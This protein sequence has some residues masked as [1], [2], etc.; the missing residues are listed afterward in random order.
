MSSLDDLILHP[1]TLQLAQKIAHHLP[2][3]LIIDGPAGSGTLTLAAALAGEVNSP[4][5]VLQPK[6]K[7][8]GEFVVDLSE[9]SII[10]DDIRRLY[11][12]TRTKQPGEQVYI[13]DTG[14]KSMTLGA[15]N[16]F[17]KLL[18]EPR[19]GLHFIIATHQ[20]AQLLPTITSRSQRLSLLPVTDA[21][22][23][24]LIKDLNIEDETKRTRL[25]FVGRGLPALIKRLV[26]DEMLYETR[27]AIMRDAK[28]MISGNT[29]DK[30]TIAHHYR[31]NR[32]GA[33]TL[34]DDMNHQLRTVVRSQPDQKLVSD[35]DK[36]LST[37]G[38]I[39]ASG[40]IRL[41]LAADVL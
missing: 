28:T 16:A 39:A 35:I 15:Q 11:E 20:Y 25:A 30:L 23:N 31:D 21:Q 12:Q 19:A 33:L 6:K 4:A 36:H 14:E 22:T 13:I 17:L 26:D 1:R 5:F 38:H 18:E 24:T 9:G 37:R 2:H 7:V 34:L 40:N 41:H 8:K 32:P 29:Y 3:G 27:V 10:I